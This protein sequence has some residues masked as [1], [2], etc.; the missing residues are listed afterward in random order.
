MSPSL[1]GLVDKTFIIRI[2]LGLAER[3][4]LKLRICCKFKL[5]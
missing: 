3:L 4:I 1:A 5:N 2:F